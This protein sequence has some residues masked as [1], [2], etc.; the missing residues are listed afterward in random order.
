MFP[1]V[2][3][4]INDDRPDTTRTRVYISSDLDFAGSVLS[5]YHSS[6][7]RLSGSD[8]RTICYPTLARRLT[9]TTAAT[10]TP[11][12]TTNWRAQRN[13]P[14]VRVAVKN[15]ECTRRRG[16]VFDFVL[17]RP[18]QLFIFLL[19]FA[20]TNTDFSCAALPPSLWS[21]FLLSTTVRPWI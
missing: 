5:L 2:T 7:G 10:A 16:S 8:E 12:T 3:R 17:F 6:G 14:A 18:S 11:W 20:F 15:D 9:P 4:T 13:V 1:R 21:V 19:P